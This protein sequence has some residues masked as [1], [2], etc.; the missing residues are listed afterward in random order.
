MDRSSFCQMMKRQRLGEVLLSCG[1]KEGRIS[2]DFHHPLFLSP[3]HVSRSAQVTRCGVRGNGPGKKSGAL[4]CPVVSLCTT[5]SLYLLLA[6][7]WA[8]SVLTQ[9]PSMSGSK[10]ERVTISC[11]G[12]S[13]NIRSYGVN[14]YQHL[15]GMALNLIIYW[16]NRI[17]SGTPNQLSDSRPGSSGSLKITWLQTEDKAEYNCS[18]WVD[19]LSSHTVFHASEEMRQYPAV[20]TVMRFPYVMYIFLVEYELFYCFIFCLT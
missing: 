3:P 19:S 18:T 7:S 12:S 14:W 9:P 13:A 10:G 8:Q 11:S 1:A 6:G 2:D 20:Q 5:L 4:L 17:A 15:P 16:D